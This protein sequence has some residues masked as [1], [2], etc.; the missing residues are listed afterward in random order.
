MKTLIAYSSNTGNTEKLAKA[1][2]QVVEADIINIK[3]DPN[4]EDYD[5][6]IV[7]YWGRRGRADD[8]ADAFLKK[9][10]GKKVGV[11]AT[12]GAYPGTERAEKV[13]NYGIETLKAQGNQVVAHYYCHGQIDPGLRE[14]AQK[15]P[16]DDPHAWTPQREERFQ[17][18]LGHPNQ[19][20]LEKAKE[21]FKDFD[22]GE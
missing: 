7:G 9:I 2:G 10:Q 21:A 17:A 4:I 22:L 20:D 14:R 16:M 1:I 6:I 19:E 12:L 3:D 8:Q 18:A 13:I 5:N 15:R 11:F